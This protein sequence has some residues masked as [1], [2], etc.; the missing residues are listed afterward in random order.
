MLRGEQAA[1]GTIYK[2]R[3]ARVADLPLAGSFGAQ[4]DFIYLPG[5]RVHT[6][7]LS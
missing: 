5:G 2:D 3:V 6:L 1:E 7:S 4:D